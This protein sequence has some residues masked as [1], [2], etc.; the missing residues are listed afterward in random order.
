MVMVVVMAGQVQ[1]HGIPRFVQLDHLLHLRP[2]HDSLCEE[3]TPARPTVHAIH[4]AG[5]DAHVPVDAIRIAEQRPDVALGIPP[6]HP[7]HVQVHEV[8]VPQALGDIAPQRTSAHCHEQHLGTLLVRGQQELLHEIPRA[9][10]HIAIVAVGL[11]Q[12]GD[13][14]EGNH[15]LEQ[16][17][18]DVLRQR[19]G[20]ASLEQAEELVAHDGGKYPADH[21]PVR[22]VQ[23]LAPDEPLHDGLVALVLASVVAV[24]VVVGFLDR[25]IVARRRHGIVRPQRHRN[26]PPKRKE[27]RQRIVRRPRRGEDGV[28]HPPNL[29]GIE[30]LSNEPGLA[31]ESRPVH[32]EQTGST[33]VG[34]T[35]EY[36]DELLGLGFAR[37][38]GD[39]RSDVVVACATVAAVAVTA[40]VVVVRR[41]RSPEHG[42]LFESR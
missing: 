19:R 37:G 28:S 36:L 16:R 2:K 34:R 9:R 20:T 42:I 40:A 4:D 14:L 41:Q 27:G 11:E 10:I 31:R 29:N 15:D 7:L 5:I 12:Q 13:R 38:Y 26:D 32:V 17:V 22:F 25:R 18:D 30:S 24:V 21:E 23:Y 6:I 8:L 39:V 35:A 1:R 33:V 3:R